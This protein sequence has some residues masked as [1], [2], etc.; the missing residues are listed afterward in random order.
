MR[1]NYPM[2]KTLCITLAAFGLFSAPLA[3]QSIGDVVRADILPGWQEADGSRI[4]AIRLRLDPGWKT[5]WRAPGDAGIPPRFDWG[6]SGNLSDISVLWPTP[7]VLSQNGMQ[8]IGYREEVVLPLRIT[9]RRSGKQVHLRAALEIGVCRDICVPRR[10]RVS[11]RLPAAQ[12]PRDPRIAS[13]IASRPLTED[14]AGLKRAD[15][16]IAATGEGLSVTARLHLP[17][18]GAP[19]VVVIEPGNPLLWVSEAATR[20]EGGTLVATSRVV[21]AEGASFMVD[22]SALRI[23]VLGRDHAVDIRGCA[24]G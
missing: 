9:P 24:A 6:G 10:I 7:E 19:E 18:A 4:A 1:H 16:R 8:S 22:R 20:R 11:A 2:W 21:H 14:E 5:Y 3:A 17:D 12:Q 13:A 23:T 15:C